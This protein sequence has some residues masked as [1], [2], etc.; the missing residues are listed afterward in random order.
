M[1][2]E[3]NTLDVLFVKDGQQG[4]DGKVLYTWIKY[5]KDANGTGMTDDPNGA[6]ILVFL[7]IMKAL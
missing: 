1:V 7:T 2:L 3:S 6:I 4:E 5:A